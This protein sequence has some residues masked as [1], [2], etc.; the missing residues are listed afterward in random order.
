MHALRASVA[1]NAALACGGV[2]DFARRAKTW[3][4]N[5][6]IRMVRQFI[7]ISLY[8]LSFFTIRKRDQ[9]TQGAV[10]GCF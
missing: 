8:S 6:S 4:E 3:R 7:W 2:F 5:L 10:K 9:T 1:A